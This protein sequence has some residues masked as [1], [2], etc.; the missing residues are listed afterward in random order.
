MNKTGIKITILIA[1]SFTMLL[2]LLN[3]VVVYRS[4]QTFITVIQD[5]T[6]Y[7]GQ[8]YPGMGVVTAFPA[9][10]L[11]TQFANQ[12][13]QSIWLAIGMGILA[14]VGI[15][16]LVSRI[17]T[18]PL[19]SLEDGIRLLEESDYQVF[20]EPTG[21]PEFDLVIEEFN[22]L[23]E[24]LS[25]V[26]TL[27][28]DLI[29]DT[30]HELRTPITSLIAQLEGMKDKVLKVT[31]DRLETVLNQ[32]YRLNDVVER[33]Q[34]YSRLRSKTA[35]LKLVKFNLYDTINKLMSDYKLQ[36]KRAKIKLKLDIPEDLTIKAD[37][38]LFERIIINLTENTLRY[39]QASEISISAE[40]GELVFADNGVG[41][42]KLHLPYIFE[43][44]YRVEK[45]RS[46][47]TG[48]VG[49]GLAIVKEIVEAH[50]WR[51]GAEKSAK[52]KGISFRI[53]CKTI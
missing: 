38:A 17:I 20:I 15:G 43:R 51:I 5:Q 39:A 4:R 11:G 7:G 26:E 44:F 33:L 2:L 3:F 30:S 48:G 10:P 12:F 21:S 53:I 37:K 42:S 32:A 35:K 25:K 40:E 34:E 8:F 1:A 50:G 45:S 13:Q 23:A 31:P 16:W 27:R 41:I 24:E 22:N 29:S 47:E 19:H 52:Q 9:E 36:L 6:S 18:R 49:L 28:K 46:R 14:S